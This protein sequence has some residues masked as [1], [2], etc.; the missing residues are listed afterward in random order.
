[1]DPRDTLRNQLLNAAAE[2]PA[3]H[4]QY[5]QEVQ[6]MLSDLEKK[7]NF[8]R[9]MAAAQWIFIV[10]LSTSFMLIGGY[11]HETMT[12]MWFGVQGVFWFLF[13]TVFL[14]MYRFSQLK[15]DMLTEIKR[16]ELAVLELKES[17]QAK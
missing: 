17:M 8:E 12:G 15:L 11:K 3:R 13:G 7:V 1:M 9:R 2:R 14:L 5:Q 16:V 6:A 10:V 4:I